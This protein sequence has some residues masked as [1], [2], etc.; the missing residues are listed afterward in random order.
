ML[1][2]EQSFY[3]HCSRG[4]VLVERERSA[5]LLPP[6]FGGGGCDARVSTR[7]GGWG[8]LGV[9]TGSLRFLFLNRPADGTV[10]RVGA[11]S[12]CGVAGWAAFAV[13]HKPAAVAVTRDGVQRSF[14]G[15]NSS[16]NLRDPASLKIIRCIQQALRSS[17]FCCCSGS[18]WRLFAPLSHVFFVSLY[19]LISVHAQLSL[20][21]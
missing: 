17:F 6:F 11:S 21:S 5:S 3:C 9:D 14:M 8:G 19:C 20:R 4:A 7:E 10:R 15:G 18:K 13:K 16:L 2:P 12:R 1:F